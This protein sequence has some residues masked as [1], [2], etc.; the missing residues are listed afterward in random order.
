MTLEPL[1]GFS[2]LYGAAVSWNTSSEVSV[3]GFGGLGFTASRFG[4][5]DAGAGFMVYGLR[6]RD[7]GIRRLVAGFVCKV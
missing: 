3:Q 5:M 1:L 4:F 2:A 6:F 7:I